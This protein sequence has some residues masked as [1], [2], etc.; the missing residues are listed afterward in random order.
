MQLRQTGA[1]V[2]WFARAADTKA[3]AHDFTGA[4]SGNTI[5]G[6]FQDRPGYQV[7]NRGVI[8][9]RIADDCHFVITGVGVNGAPPT[10]GGERLPPPHGAPMNT[11]TAPATP[12]TPNRVTRRRTELAPRRAGESVASLGASG[13]RV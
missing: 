4:I 11:S 3:W 2:I 13:P 9:A 1:T 12:S 10:G 5:S 7:H 6:S 8:T